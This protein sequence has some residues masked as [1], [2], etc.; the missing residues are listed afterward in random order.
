MFKGYRYLIISLFVFLACSREDD[1]FTPEIETSIPKV[2]TS[3]S[4]EDIEGTWFVYAG[5]FMDNLVET[6]PN[7]SECGFDYIVFSDNGV[8]QEFLYSNSDCI[9]TIN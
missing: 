3:V 5:E 7:F 8:Y 6:T 1:K 9:Q 2:D 4:T